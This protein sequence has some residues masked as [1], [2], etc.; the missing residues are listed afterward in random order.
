MNIL[1]HLYQKKLVP[2]QLWG[3]DVSIT[4]GVV[5]MWLSLAIILLFF[6]LAARRPRLVPRPLQNLAEM[7]IIFTR[8][9]IGSQIESG[10]EKW[11]P[12]L[13]AIFSFV[14]VNNLLGLIP[15]LGA[16]TNNI[17]V[18]AALAVIVFL[19]V[20]VAGVYKL[21]LAGYLKKYIPEGIPFFVVIFMIPVEILSQLARP[22]S[23]AVRLFANMFAGHAVMLLL[24][25]MIFI[26]KSYIILPVP[27]LGN[28]AFLAFELFIAAIQAFVF[29]YL[30]AFYIAT[31]LEEEH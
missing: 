18:T 10:G 4:N 24:I 8:D 31:A 22:F 23:L 6:Y 30:S 1:E 27:V 15:G 12:L 3:I 21:G 29:T 13:V 25:T 7:F 19:T 5:V 26:F 2:L 17:N 20:Q 11:L 14:L 16:S 9:E 28:T